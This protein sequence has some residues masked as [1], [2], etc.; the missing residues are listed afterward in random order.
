MSDSDSDGGPGLDGILW[1]NLGENGNRLELD[2]MDEVSKHAST[3]SYYCNTLCSM[4]SGGLWWP[5][6]PIQPPTTARIASS[7]LLSCWHGDGANHILQCWTASSCATLACTHSRHALPYTCAVLTPAPVLL[8]SCCAECHQRTGCC[9][10]QDGSGRRPAG[11]LNSTLHQQQSS[12]T[13]THQSYLRRT[14]YSSQSTSSLSAVSCHPPALQ[15]PRKTDTM[16]CLL[17]CLVTNECCVYA[18][19]MFWMCRKRC[20]LLEEVRGVQQQEQQQAHPALRVPGQALTM[21][22]SQPY[23]KIWRMRTSLR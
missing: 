19:C 11:K 3:G 17:A 16:L 23:Q 1:G 8:C 2:Y 15:W 12:S 7:C 9:P 4:H 10:T 20:P 21:Q 22:M 5:Q 13:L 18:C 6:P 14:L